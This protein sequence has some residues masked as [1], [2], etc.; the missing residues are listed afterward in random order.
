[1]SVEINPAPGA[2]SQA[3]V[4]RLIRS[5]REEQWLSLMLLALHGGLILELVD[6][7]ARALLTSHFGLFGRLPVNPD[8]ADWPALA[9]PSTDAHAGKS[10]RLLPASRYC[11]MPPG[12]Y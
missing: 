2:E 8:Q 10:G 6:P 1:M 9:A 5:L 7:L 11:Q 4:S 3:R 12:Q